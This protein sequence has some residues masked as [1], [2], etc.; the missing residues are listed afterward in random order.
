MGDGDLLASTGLLAA[1]TAIGLAAVAGLVAL[2]LRWRRRRAA[3]PAAYHPAAPELSA[4]P[5]PAPAEPDE[6]RRAFVRLDAA[7]HLLGSLRSLH[8]S[9]VARQVSFRQ[10]RPFKHVVDLGLEAGVAFGAPVRA[11]FDPATRDALGP[12]V[13]ARAL[14]ALAPGLLGPLRRTAEAQG[15]SW[16]TVLDG[17]DELVPAARQRH[18]SE[19]I[20]EL[21]VADVAADPALRA[22]VDE[23]GA[24]PLWEALA[25]G[26]PLLDSTEAWQDGRLLG[27]LRDHAGATLRHIQRLQSRIEVELQPALERIERAAPRAE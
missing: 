22:L 4:S 12:E 19:L 14:Q 2:A 25:T 27:H 20:D 16:L 15:V 7:Q 3:P 6:L 11:R 26:A 13:S 17:A 1:L 10:S 23:H 24:G 21:G 8:G 9:L 5:L 18:V